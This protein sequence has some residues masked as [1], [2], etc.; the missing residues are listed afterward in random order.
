LV[1]TATGED[2][3]TSQPAP[4]AR[5]AREIK[6]I[7]EA[8]RRGEPFL[9]WR[10]AGD[11]H[12]VGL[13]G[14]GRVTLGRASSCDVVL[15][16]D[17]EISRIHA[18]LQRVGDEWAIVDDGLSTNGTFVNG[19]RISGRRRLTDGDVVRLGT[20]PIEYRSAGEGS[21]VATSAAAHKPQLEPLSETQRKILL[22]LCRP[23]KS[24]N[25][26]AT[27]ASNNEIAAEVFLTADAVKSNL[28]VLFSRFEVGDLPRNRKRARLVECAF[29]WGV[30]TE[31]D[32]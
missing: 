18:E 12:I 31:R 17:S 23:Y 9:L 5:S 26:Y 30:V 27:P 3:V 2:A 28:R 25:T 21:T 19:A 6:A 15:R 20:T 24:G 4:H 7:I 10:G 22:A 32:L 14:L 8:E 11:H 29:Q 1:S 13:G 16:H